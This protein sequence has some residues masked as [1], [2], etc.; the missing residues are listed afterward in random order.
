MFVFVQG[1]RISGY[2]AW[3]RF[4]GYA[5]GLSEKH[6]DAHGVR[7]AITSLAA[8]LCNQ[9]QALLFA[10]SLRQ[11]VPGSLTP[12][13]PVGEESWQNPTIFLRELLQSR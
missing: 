13:V 2:F 7:R 10:R 9:S 12:I 3:E 4:D 11:L 5:R 8:E 1:S 6:G